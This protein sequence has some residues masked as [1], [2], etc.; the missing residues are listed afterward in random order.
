[1]SIRGKD[2]PESLRLMTRLLALGA[3]VD[4]Y[5][6]DESW[7]WDEVGFPRGTALHTVSILNCAAAAEMLLL[8]GADPLCKQKISSVELSDSS[9][10]D[11]ARRE[12]H[13]SEVV[14]ILQGYIE[15]HG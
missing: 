6:G 14:K 3:P 2:V 5:E 8:H 1:M 7:F 4:K 15:Q 11:V 12:N 9:A 13:Y 10:L